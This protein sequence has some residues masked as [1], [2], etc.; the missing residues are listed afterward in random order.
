MTSDK[1]PP[2]GAFAVRQYLLTP[3]MGK[4]LIARAVVALPAVQAVLKKGRLVV[5]AGSTNGYV[6][7]EVLKSVDQADGFERRGFRRGMV[8]PPGFQAPGGSEFAGDVV[9]VD[10]TWERSKTI[11]DVAD[12]LQTGDV[13][14]KGANA[15]DVK[16]GNA[17][18]YIGH[19]QGGTILAALAAVVGRRVR[20]IAPV[21][22]EKRICGD[23]GEIAS[24]LNAA[25]ADGP[26][27]LPLPGPAFT[28][29]DAIAV[30][31]GAEATLVAG[32]GIYG[33]EGCVYVAVRGTAEQLEAAGALVASL[34]DEPPCEV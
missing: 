27:M 1:T 19:P 25:N 8:T 16:T 20:L 11:F 29:L 34:R 33:A 21:G 18:V 30:L 17:A 4:R 14:L 15:V 24:M 10:G 5:I 22:L 28:E 7:E 2:A 23:V 3:A 32:G 31:T 13:V 9:L 6:A 12:D 26:R